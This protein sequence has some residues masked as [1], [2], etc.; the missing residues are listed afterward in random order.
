MTIVIERFHP[1][2]F[3]QPFIYLT[4]SEKFTDI[5]KSLKNRQ[6]P[7]LDEIN[8]LC[9]KQLHK[10]GV[11]TLTGSINDYLHLYYFPRI[12][13]LVMKFQFLSQMLEIIN[14]PGQ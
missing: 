4:K 6:S 2:A 13:K 3:K 14:C 5:M 1:I 12:W 8:N 11:D 10:K 7:C 9:L